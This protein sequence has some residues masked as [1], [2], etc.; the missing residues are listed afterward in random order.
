MS[1]LDELRGLRLGRGQV[2]LVWLGQAGFALR[3]AGSTVLVDPFLSARSDRRVAAPL[4]ADEAIGVDV[5][6]CT[7]EHWDHL[8]TETVA[9]VA[10]ASPQ[11]TIVVPRPLVDLVTS[12][13]IGAERVVGAQPTESIEIGA[14]IIHPLPARHGVDMADAYDFGFERSNGLYRYLGYVVELAGVRV[15][16]AGDTIAYEGMADRIGEVDVD[17]ALLP[18]NGRDGVREAA[19]IVGNLDAAEALALAD[20]AGVDLLVPMHYE[21]F[22]ANPGHPAHLVEIAQRDHPRVQ[23]LLPVHGRPFVYTSTRADSAGSGR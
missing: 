7:H 8:D 22:E 20:R 12:L 16:H 10:A 13:G 9:A 4:R 1:T 15:Y 23:I 11:A 17:V 18:I 5:V 6:A 14:V 21:M 19:N 3:G 2:A